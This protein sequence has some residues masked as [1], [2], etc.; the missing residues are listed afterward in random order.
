MNL[1]V[2]KTQETQG[3]W[4]HTYK[5]NWTFNKVLSDGRVKAPCLDSHSNTN[6]AVMYIK[7][8]IKFNSSVDW[9]KSS[10]SHIETSKEQCCLTCTAPSLK[11][12]RSQ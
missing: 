12:C 6:K 7:C 4:K 1:K 9:Q 8:W 11:P 3:D 5:D 10:N 2:F